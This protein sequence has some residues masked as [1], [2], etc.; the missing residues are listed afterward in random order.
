MI[1]PL[2]TVRIPLTEIGRR[3]A[4]RVLQLI[5]SGQPGSADAD[6]VPA[7]LICRATA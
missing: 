3:A 6:M 7:E 4:Q 5:A 2:T 1:P